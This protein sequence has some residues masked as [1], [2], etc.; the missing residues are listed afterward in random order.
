M[1]GTR[2]VDTPPHA[3]GAAIGAAGDGRGA[4][5]HG[6]EVIRT[7]DL[8]KVYAG[9][10]FAAVD[11][12]NLTSEAGEIFGLLGPNGAGKT[13][14]AGMLTTRVVPTSGAGVRRRRRRRRPPGA[15]QAAERD[16]LPAEHPRPAAD[17][18]GEPVLPRPPVRHGRGR[19]ARAPPTSC[20]SSSS[21]PSGPRRRSTR[22]R[23]AWPSGSWWRAPSSTVRPCCSWTSRPPAS[24]RRAA[25]RCGTSSASCN[26]EGQTILLTTHYMEE[27]DTAL[28]PGGDHGP[29]QDP[30][31][32]HA[33]RAQALG[34]RRHDRHR[35]G[36]AAT[37]T[38]SAA[39][40]DRAGRAA[41]RATR[42]TTAASS[43]T[44]RAATGWCR[45]S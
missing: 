27:A 45:G 3:P 26:G 23:A 25:S 24:T 14:T 32:G 31:A 29:R 21:W 38:R 22:C 10:D 35:Q 6:G 34:R 42:V 16:R 33:R 12:L 43:C 44:S 28:R 9:T 1:A 36:R 4:D 13:T 40:A 8:T 18:L 19:V 15:G 39:R 30:R 5:G 20:S 17:R 7:V 41:S 11:K 37:R 2:P